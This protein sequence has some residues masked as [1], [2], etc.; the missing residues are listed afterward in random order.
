MT[1]S[2]V[3]DRLTYCSPADLYVKLREASGLPRGSVLVL[4]AHWALESGFGHA[5]HCWNIGNVKWTPG[6]GYD[7]CAFLAGET[8]HGQDVKSV[9][10]FRAYENLDAG[11]ADYLVRLRAEFRRAWPA[12]EA[13]NVVDFCHDLK[14]AAYYTA[15]EDQYVAGVLRCFR[16]LDATISD[17][18]AIGPVLPDDSQDTPPPDA[19]A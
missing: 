1:E 10:R 16:Q 9:M 15:P 17:P 8:E 12:V 4:L 19:D 13:G 14:L 6:C 7:Y 18:I 11:V 2:L 5:M 3:P